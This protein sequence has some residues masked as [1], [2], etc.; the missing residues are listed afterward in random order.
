MFPTLLDLGHH[1]LPLLGRTHLFLP[2]YGL[3]FAV[4]A[5]LAWY[6]F[7]RRA[8]RLD[9][10]DEPL[11]NLS[12]YTLLAGLLGAKLTLILVD[13]PYYLENPGA[14]LGTLRTAGVLI[15]GIF[16]AGLTFILYCRRNDLKVWPLAD[17]LAAPL[18]LAQAV[19]RLGCFAAGC[20]HGVPTEGRFHVV[21][22]DPM[23][24]MAT[25]FLN[26]PLVPI[27]LVEAAFDLALV[28]GLTLLYRKGG[29]EP[30]TIFWIYALAYALFRIV[31]EFWRG[32]LDRGIWLDGAVS[33]S[34]IL[35]GGGVLLA[36]CMI[37]WLQRRGKS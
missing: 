23:A 35:S 32:D 3:L 18:A 4:G 17:A 36:A 27:Q 28:A 25:E 26:V 8:K 12:F 37:V 5:V 33:T 6:W 11:F 2:T 34:Q 9:H 22:T 29:R 16:F 30:G 7:M 15:G 14:I 19:G 21:F 24:A 20:C 31:V 10:P 1:D 13:L